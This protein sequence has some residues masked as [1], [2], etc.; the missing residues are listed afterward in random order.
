MLLLHWVRVLGSGSLDILLLLL[1]LRLLLSQ[2]LL[3]DIFT[4]LLNRFH[5]GS[6]VDSSVL[7]I[8]IINQNKYQT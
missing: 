3:P 6:I 8:F 2:L 5:F 4:F 1:L 7:Q